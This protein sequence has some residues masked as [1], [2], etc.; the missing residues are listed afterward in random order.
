MLGRGRVETEGWKGGVPPASAQ[1]ANGLN[2]RCLLKR[3]RWT[4]IGYFVC[5]ADP[6]QKKLL[7]WG[8]TE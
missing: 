8:Q 2:E 3:G 4:E 5:L 1:A 7:L 6:A